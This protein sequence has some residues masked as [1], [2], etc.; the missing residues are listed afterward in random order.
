MCEYLML[1]MV[2]KMKGWWQESA[3]TTNPREYP[4]EVDDSRTVRA[5]LMIDYSKMQSAKLYTDQ[6][7]NSR[8]QTALELAEL[9]AARDARERSKDTFAT[10]RAFPR[11]YVPLELL[12]FQRK[13][14]NE[15][16]R[17][18]RSVWR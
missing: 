3:R 8:H 7:I 1:M 9:A 11:A 15:M 2:L 6:V 16:G 14:V 13:E 10:R 18:V 5:G 12:M 4:L 17:V